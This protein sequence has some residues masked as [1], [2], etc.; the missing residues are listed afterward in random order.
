MKKMFVALTLAAASSAYAGDL[1]MGLGFPFYTV[2]YAH[3]VN[4]AVGVRGEFSGLRTIK[5]DGTEDGINY[6]GRFK[7][8]VFGAYGDWHP[9]NGGFRVVGGLTVNDTKL[10]L[11]ATSGTGT[12]NINGKTVNLSGETYNVELT[13]PRVTPYVG[14]GYGFSPANTPGFGFY[15]DL[16]VLIGRFKTETTTSLVGKQGITQAD[17]DAE[18][19]QLR[20]STAKLSALPKLSVGVTYRF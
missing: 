15:A 18:T 19:G 3:T 13:Y 1:Y 2:G 4:D 20:D 17:V 12:A 8:Q 14:L 6:Q 9:M 7:H 16:G 5:R 11:N 10:N